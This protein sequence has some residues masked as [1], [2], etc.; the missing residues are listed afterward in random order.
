MRN[1]AK[2]LE[3]SVADEIG[4]EEIESKPQPK[5]GTKRHSDTWARRNGRRAKDRKRDRKLL[6]SQK[7]NKRRRDFGLKFEH[8]YVPLLVTSGDRLNDLF[9]QR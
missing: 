4:V 7:A 3:V 9:A 5:P 2:A 8:Q 1:S 6:S